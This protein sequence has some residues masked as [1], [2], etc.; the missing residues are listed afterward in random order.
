[1]FSHIRVGVS[2]ATNSTFRIKTPVEAR[3]RSRTTPIF[4]ET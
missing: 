4:W 3:E 1:M 2:G